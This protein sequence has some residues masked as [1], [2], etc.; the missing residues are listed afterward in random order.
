[1][2][3]MDPEIT[4]VFN[5]ISIGF[6]LPYVIEGEKTFDEVMD[7]YSGWMSI[8]VRGLLT[9]GCTGHAMMPLATASILAE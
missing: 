1:M 5:G 7:T 6:D 9:R 8:N 2:N 4:A 3:L